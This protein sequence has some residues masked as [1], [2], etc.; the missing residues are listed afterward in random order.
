M[1]HSMPGEIRKQACWKESGACGDGAGQGAEQGKGQAWSRGGVTYHFGL[2][3]WLH[4]PLLQQRPV[5]SLEKGVSPDV[6]CYSQPLDRVPL[7]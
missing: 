4:L 6:S 2:K 7:E 3:R 5:D 1:V